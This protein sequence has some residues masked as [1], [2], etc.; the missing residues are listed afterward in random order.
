[1]NKAEIRQAQLAKLVRADNSWEKEAQELCLY[2][3][4]FALSCWKKAQ[5]IGLTLSQKGEID[6]KPLILQARLQHKRICLPRT[7]PQRQL[8]F[9]ELQ[10]TSKLE[11][12]SFGIWQPALTERKVAKNALDLL[13][14]PGLAFTAQGQRIGY[15][16][17]YYDRFLAGFAGDTVALAERQ[18]FFTTA[19]WQT[20]TTDQIVQQVLTI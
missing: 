12:S 10:K 2:E 20:A 8:Q 13:I 4:L 18:R 6:T 11:K 5:T 7:L 9:F 3:Q 15:G 19:A 14:I 1:M 17:G 16:G